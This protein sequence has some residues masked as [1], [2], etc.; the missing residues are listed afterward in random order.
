MSKNL[1]E[2]YKTSEKNINLCLVKM[3]KKL[4]INKANLEEII[5]SNFNKE[6][7]VVLSLEA[8]HVFNEHGSSGEEVQIRT[9][10]MIILTEKQ[11]N[12]FLFIKKKCVI[13]I[14]DYNGEHTYGEVKVEIITNNEAISA[15]KT[16]NK[17]VKDSRNLYQEILDNTPED[18]KFKSN[19]VKKL[20]EEILD[21]KVIEGKISGNLFDK[22]GALDTP[23]FKEQLKDIIKGTDLKLKYIDVLNIYK[24]NIWF[25]YYLY[26]KQLTGL[27]YK[28]NCTDEALEPVIEIFISDKINIEIFPSFDGEIYSNNF[29]LKN[30]CLFN[31]SYITDKK[32]NGE[33]LRVYIN[34]NDI[35][36]IFELLK[37]HKEKNYDNNNYVDWTTATSKE[38][39]HRVF[40]II[41][42]FP[43]VSYIWK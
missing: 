4:N 14:N 34:Y 7:L 32:H 8:D 43:H 17:W 37:I 24:A 11:L 28:I 38:E 41:K 1:A 23:E 35:K 26:S 2:L 10:Q 15:F 40:S 29:K 16:L 20:E 22:I 31:I 18:Q 5:L 36:N 19:E 9:Q 6:N 39:I 3:S 27:N 13:V 42:S 30:T 33:K 12:D 21:I 25:M